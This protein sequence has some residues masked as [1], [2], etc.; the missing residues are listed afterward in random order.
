MNSIVVLFVL[1]T[2]SKDPDYQAHIQNL[3]Q[4]SNNNEEMNSTKDL[5]SMSGSV[6]LSSSVVP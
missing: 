1:A 6:L 2:N 4:Q 3:V 5:Q